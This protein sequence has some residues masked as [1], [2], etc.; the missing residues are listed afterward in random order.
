MLTSLASCDKKSWVRDDLSFAF[1]FFITRK[2]F[3]VKN[4]LDDENFFHS[5]IFS[6]KN[7]FSQKKFFVNFFHAK[8][9]SVKNFFDEE[10]FLREL[11]SHTFAWWKLRHILLWSY[12]LSPIFGA[13]SL[14]FVL[15]HS[16]SA[17]GFLVDFLIL[18]ELLDFF[19]KSSIPSARHPP[20]TPPPIPGRARVTKYR[21]AH[22]QI[23]EQAYLTELI[24]RP[25]GSL[26]NR[27]F[28]VLGEYQI[29]HWSRR[30]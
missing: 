29:R 3:S 18:M 25:A 14:Y 15:V 1:A 10:N 8:I 5:K 28:A 4:F 9:F 20:K 23:D 2:I 6:V 26:L 7:F 24:F 22:Q 11:C 19:Y 17:G 16:G 13:P 12:F 27:S 30:H 21:R